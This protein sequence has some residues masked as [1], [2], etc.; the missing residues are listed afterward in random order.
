M[1]TRFYWT[2]RFAAWAVESWHAQATAALLTDN[3]GEAFSIYTNWNH[4]HGRL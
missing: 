2:S 4:Y 1:C 3:E